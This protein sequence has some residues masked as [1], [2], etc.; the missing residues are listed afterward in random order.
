VNYFQIDTDHYFVPGVLTATLESVGKYVGWYGFSGKDWLEN[1]IP[2]KDRTEEFRRDYLS[3]FSEQQIGAVA[4]HLEL[5]Q[6]CLVEKRGYPDN[7]LAR[8]I[9][10]IWKPNLI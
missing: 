5:F 3:H 8:A 4:S 2:S 6:R 7:D 1:L 10:E 9:N